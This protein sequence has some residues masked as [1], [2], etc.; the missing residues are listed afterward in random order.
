MG[1][2]FVLILREMYWGNLMLTLEG[3]PKGKFYINIRRNVYG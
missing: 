2:N 1:A 3:Q